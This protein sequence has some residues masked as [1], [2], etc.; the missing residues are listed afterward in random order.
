MK[1]VSSNQKLMWAFN[2]SKRLYALYRSIHPGPTGQP[3][4]T[5]DFLKS[6]WGKE[7]CEKCGYYFYRGPCWLHFH[8]EKWFP[9]H[10]RFC[11]NC[12]IFTTALSACPNECDQC[13]TVCTRC[14]SENR[15]DRRYVLSFGLRRFSCVAPRVP[16]RPL[17]TAPPQAVLP[18]PSIAS[19]QNQ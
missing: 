4:S 10:M 11:K 17:L 12:Q 5:R 18:A 8:L 7:S 14:G 3:P 6:C 16:L 1:Q 19:S 15:N 9:E 13:G 2:H